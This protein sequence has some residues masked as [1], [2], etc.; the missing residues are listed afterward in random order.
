MSVRVAVLAS[1]GGSNLQAIL[2]HNAMLGAAAHAEIALVATDRPGAKALDRAHAHGIATATLQ[3]K[4]NSDGVALDRALVEHGIEL[5]ALAG[6]LRLVP[7]EVVRRYEGRIV[8]VHPA[9]LPSFGGAGMY[10]HHVHE[11]V[12]A[13]GVTVTGATI[14][15]VDE[16]F[17]RGTIIAQWPVPVLAG[18]D[19][20]AV[21][22]RV[23]K[24]EH[25]LY[26]RVLDAVAAGRLS[27]AHCRTHRA[28]TAP[29]DAAFALQDSP[30][31]LAATLDRALA[32]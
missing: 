20:D 23:L 15:Y 28:F 8:N 27:A 4:R 19:A 5:I 17:D 6:Y 7:P 32:G 25:L 9:L 22:A 21:A 18:D 11:A 12:I 26:P 16:E 13:A 2:D 10:G 29:T 3:T 24:V 31:A 1:G 30:E 14:H